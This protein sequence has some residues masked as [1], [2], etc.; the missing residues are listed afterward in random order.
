[1][2]ESTTSI[3]EAGDR[4]G[5]GTLGDAQKGFNLM[6]LCVI[7]IIHK[8]FVA[9]G[10]AETSPNDAPGHRDIYLPITGL[11]YARGNAC[12]VIIEGC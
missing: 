7:V 8:I 4:I 12:G 10:F 11:E 2:T 5:I 6:R 9:N 3:P 1:M